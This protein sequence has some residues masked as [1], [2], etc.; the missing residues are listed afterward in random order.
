MIV[1][2][3]RL[4]QVAALVMAA[5]LDEASSLDQINKVSG[6]YNHGFGEWVP[7]HSDN[8]RG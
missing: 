3:Y 1:D 8:E 2:L 7:F 6:T 4:D 5:L